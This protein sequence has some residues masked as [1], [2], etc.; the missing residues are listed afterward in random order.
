MS[1]PSA[2]PDGPTAEPAGKI[3][4]PGADIDHHLA[5]FQ[6]ERPHYVVGLLPF[7][8]IW[9]FEYACPMRHVAEAMVRRRCMLL[10]P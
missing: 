1:S 4:G 6:V 8:T 5:T 9:R 2:S 3:A 7:G 10:G